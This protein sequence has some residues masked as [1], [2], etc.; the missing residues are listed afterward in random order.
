MKWS[1]DLCVH[2][3]LHESQAIISIEIDIEKSTILM[4][5]SVGSVAE[6]A[7]LALDFVLKTMDNRIFF[8]Q[9]IDPNADH[10]RSII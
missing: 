3:G 5:W 1:R 9:T 2:L 4:E 7:G 6:C 8:L 10:I